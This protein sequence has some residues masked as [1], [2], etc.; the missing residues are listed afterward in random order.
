MH[1]FEGFTPFWRRFNRVLSLVLVFLIL[2]GIGYLAVLS[3]R[4]GGADAEGTDQ[5]L[6]SPSEYDEPNVRIGLCYGSSVRN[7]YTFSSTGNLTYGYNV[8]TNS[9]FVALGSLPAGDYRVSIGAAY[10]VQLALFSDPH[11]DS[12]DFEAVMAKAIEILGVYNLP[13]FPP[14]TVTFFSEVIHLNAQTVAAH[15][16]PSSSSFTLDQWNG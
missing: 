11:T 1:R 4:F 14:L 2:A 9:E 5:L 6:P 8:F 10:T 15:P 13:I 3:V 16:F 12:N 7:V